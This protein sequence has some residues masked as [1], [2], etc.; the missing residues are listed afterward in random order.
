[1]ISRFKVLGRNG[2]CREAGPPGRPL[3]L[4]SWV[5]RPRR[6]DIRLATLPTKYGERM[7]V[8]LLA[9]Q[10]ESLTLERLG[11]SPADLERFSRPSRSRTA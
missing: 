11:M 5:D 2:H 1:M 6:I 3:H 8:R 4:S 9:L 10:T 7:T